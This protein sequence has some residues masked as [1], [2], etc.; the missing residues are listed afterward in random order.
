MRRHR[1]PNACHA[2][3]TDMRITGSRATASR[4]PAF[5][6]RSCGPGGSGCFAGGG[7]GAGRSTGLGVSFNAIPS[8][9]PL[10][11]TPSAVA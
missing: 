5:A 3:P 11:F 1:T 4:S 6:M 7:R 10:R 2:T 9:L 8:R